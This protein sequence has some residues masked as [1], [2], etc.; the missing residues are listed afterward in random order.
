VQAW[1]KTLSTPRA[2]AHIKPSGVELTD[3]FLIGSIA[4]GEDWPEG[5]ENGTRAVIEFNYGPKMTACYL[6]RIMGAPEVLQGQLAN[7]QLLFN[8]QRQN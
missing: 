4:N 5:I 2:P 3:E 6:E 7:K 1:L 8:V